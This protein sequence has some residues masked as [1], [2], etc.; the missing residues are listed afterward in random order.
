MQI[1]VFAK[2]FPGSDPLIVLRSAAAAGY[3]GVQYNMACSGLAPM[4]DVIT[5]EAAQAVA[6]AAAETGQAILAVSGTY[7]MI[8]PDPSGAPRG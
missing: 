2:T 7:N 3:E 8:H 6:S 4:P 1:G 5:P